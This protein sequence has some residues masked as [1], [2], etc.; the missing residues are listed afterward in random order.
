[1][2]RI[3]Y[4]FNQ[5]IILELRLKK[6]KFVIQKIPELG[7]FISV[8]ALFF[9]F[10]YANESMS[11]I[12]TLV[13]MATQGTCIGFAAYGMSYLMITGEID[14][15]SGATAGFAAAITGLML[16]SGA[17]ELSAYSVALLAAIGV[18]ILNSIM[19]ISVTI[20]WLELGHNRFVIMRGAG[21]QHDRSS[22]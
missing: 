18:G 15:S 9:M 22:N 8:I 5:E 1:M 7:I 11:E 10:N 2:Y 20:L 13:R 4:R 6:Y 19:T 14:L 16:E 21:T 3:I 12:S 17:S